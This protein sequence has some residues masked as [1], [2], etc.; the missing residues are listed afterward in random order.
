MLDTLNERQRI[1]SNCKC[2]FKGLGV[3][4]G[5]IVFALSFYTHKALRKTDRND[6]DDILC[7]ERDINISELN[8]FPDVAD[9]TKINI[10]AM[11]TLIESVKMWKKFI[12]LIP[13]D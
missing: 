3:A 5:S 7:G 9:T 12:K 10:Y 1:Y 6:V 13:C 2:L 8:D 11:N 4:K